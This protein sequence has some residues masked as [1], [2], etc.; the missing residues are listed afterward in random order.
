MSRK[1]GPSSG[2][3]EG[4]SVA[5]PSSAPSPLICDGG[6][7]PAARAAGLLLVRTFFEPL[8]MVAWIEGGNS[9]LPMS[10]HKLLKPLSAP[11]LL[12]TTP[13]TTPTTSPSTQAPRP[14]VAT[15]MP[16][17]A[18]TAMVA[19]APM[20]TLAATSS[21]PPRMS[22]IIEVCSSPSPRRAAQSASDMCEP[23]PRTRVFLI[24]CQCAASAS[25][26]F[27]ALT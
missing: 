2:V 23:Q 26:S 22:A 9:A 7:I 10:S 20:A 14:P 5:S 13:T 17:A 24:C 25:P 11:V 15:V 1:P 21:T 3:A 8:A 6:A 27:W 18:A 4:V 19:R 16:A 12:M